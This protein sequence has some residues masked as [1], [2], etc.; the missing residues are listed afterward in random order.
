[1]LCSL[2][3]PSFPLCIPLCQRVGSRLGLLQH[4]VHRVG[5]SVLLL[6]VQVLLKP[7]LH[8][9]HVH[10]RRYKA[11]EELTGLV[12]VTQ[13]DLSIDIDMLQ[14]TPL[15]IARQQLLEND[16]PTVDISELKFS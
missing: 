14:V 9:L 1:M 3:S 7:N 2:S 10:L 16:S 11:F 13:L 12:I 15:G 5:V 6:E 8:V 4:I